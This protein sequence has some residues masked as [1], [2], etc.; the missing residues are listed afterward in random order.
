MGFPDFPVLTHKTSS[1]WLS[2]KSFSFQVRPLSVCKLCV[3][4]VTVFFAW[5]PTMAYSIQREWCKAT[6]NIKE[7]CASLCRV[8]WASGHFDSHP[9]GRG[10]LGQHLRYLWMFCMFYCAH[11]CT[12]WFENWHD[13]AFSASPVRE[14]FECH[15]PQMRKWNGME[16]LNVQST[17]RA[18]RQ[19]TLSKDSTAG[20]HKRTFSSIPCSAVVALT[21]V[22]ATA[23]RSDA[24]SQEINHWFLWYP[25]DIIIC[26]FSTLLQPF[27]TSHHGADLSSQSSHIFDLDF[28][29][30]PYISSVRPVS[31][32][33]C[34]T[35]HQELISAI[36]R[37]APGR[38]VHLFE[39]EG[40]NAVS[41]LLNSFWY[42]FSLRIHG[43]LLCSTSTL[44]SLVMQRGSSTSRL[45]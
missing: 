3:G 45:H 14:S 12:K 38:C 30:C 36:Q 31:H 37:H 13:L 18:P 22:Q 7:R 15:R 27:S 41:V 43:N 39:W 29:F 40:F 44:P 4:E 34:W 26:P 19:K 11:L 28:P 16:P 24:T 23:K 1:V 25:V 2:C 9:P 17:A 33:F 10:W 8:A 42:V 20:L 5:G 35:A 6:T 21:V 32:L